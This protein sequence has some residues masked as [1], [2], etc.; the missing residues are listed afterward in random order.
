MTNKTVDCLNKAFK[1]DPDAIHALMV[2]RVPCN[3]DLANDEHVFVSVNKILSDK[4]YTVGVL[5]LI[6]GI[7]SAND[8]P[9]V[10]MVIDDGADVKD[11]KHFYGFCEVQK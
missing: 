1:A 5:G 9:L 6:N 10:A 8:L 7:L 3:T 4:S 2:N 11:I